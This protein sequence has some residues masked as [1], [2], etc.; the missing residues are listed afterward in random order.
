M[1]GYVL[2]SKEA[3][4]LCKLWQAKPL[5]EEMRLQ[6]RFRTLVRTHELAEKIWYTTATLVR[7]LGGWLGGGA[8]PA[9]DKSDR[10]GPEVRSVL[11]TWLF[12]TAHDG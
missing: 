3:S 1:H 7:T 11:R 2:P 9:G 4:N 10:S 5:T 6:H 12:P 8:K